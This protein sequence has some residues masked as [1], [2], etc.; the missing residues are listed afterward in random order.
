MNRDRSII[1]NPTSHPRGSTGPV[2]MGP[3][4]SGRRRRMI[5]T[6]ATTAM[7]V[8]V[9]AALLPL[10]FVLGSVVVEGARVVVSS[11]WWTRP[12]PADVSHSDLAANPMMCELG[13]GDASLCGGGSSPAA[14]VMGMQP[15]IV[16]TLI[17]VV[18]ASLIAV[19]LGV[20]TALYLSEYGRNS[21]FARLVRFLTDVMIG[22]P[23]VVAGVLVYSVWVVRFGTAG[24]SAIAASLALAVVMLP[25][26]VRSSEQM[27][28]LVPDSLR[29]ASAALGGRTWWSSTSVV[30]PAAAAGIVAGCLLAIARAAGETAP[31]M[32]TI[33]FVTTTNWSFLGQNTT[34]S[35]Q[36]YSQI[37][38]GGANATALA[39]GSA[40]TLVVIV[41]LLTV[42][43]RLVT[44][45]FGGMQ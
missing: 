33:G 20:S 45:R 30:L 1:G 44:R 39:W 34:L 25:M 38:N 18:G 28:S 36:I 2:D 14:P 29:E 22:V 21:R 27:L 24:K 19:P 32:F 11:D 31:V 8:A 4:R 37:Q 41:G 15:A 10:A 7:A 9:T 23:S 26:I 16:G 42:T 17:T 40:L 35:T 5:D 12:I 43:A 13:F 3:S 6:L